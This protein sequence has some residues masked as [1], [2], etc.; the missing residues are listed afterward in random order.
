MA[1]KVSAIA[2]LTLGSFH[3]IIRWGTIL[4]TRKLKWS[5]SLAAIEKITV[6][7]QYQHRTCASKL[8]MPLR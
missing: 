3:A 8:Y 1:S 7:Q 5:T 2:S 6:V 4:R